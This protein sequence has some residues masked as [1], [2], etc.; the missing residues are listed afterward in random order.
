MTIASASR[1][2]QRAPPVLLVAVG[3]VLWATDGWLRID[4][5]GE[6]P[7]AVI[8]FMEHAILVLVTMPLWRSAIQATRRFAVGDWISLLIIGVGASAAATV[9]FTMA[10][11]NDFLTTVLLQ[12]LQPLIAVL[13]ATIILGERL[14]PR[15]WGYFVTAA[16]GAWVM[17][18]SDPLGVSASELGPALLAVGAA[19]LWALG[20]VLGRR[21]APVTTPSQLMTL[22]FAVGMPTAAIIVSMRGEWGTLSTMKASIL[23]NLIVLALVPGLL[24][25]WIYYRGLLRTPASVATLAELAFPLATVLIGYFAFDRAL[26]GSQWIGLFVL[27]GAITALGLANPKEKDAYGIRLTRD[28]ATV[29]K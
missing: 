26:D 5:V 24:A 7:A 21:M 27:V 6:L 17:T 15:Y 25:I 8:V 14:K 20:T 9:L 1:V 29:D 28:R 22:R 2:V 13:A 16:A 3:A 23:G 10:I 19:S 11:S 12:K 4:L 18:F